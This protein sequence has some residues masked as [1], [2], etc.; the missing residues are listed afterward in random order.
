[1][2]ETR[3][4]WAIP[5]AT[6]LVLMMVMF[7]YVDRAVNAHETVP[8][9]SGAVPLSRLAGIENDLRDIKAILSRLNEDRLPDI[10]RRLSRIEG[11]LGVSQ[12]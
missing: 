1:M 10:D 5:L 9:H 7:A 2:S 8:F 3:K 4:A 12:K 11:A 6:V